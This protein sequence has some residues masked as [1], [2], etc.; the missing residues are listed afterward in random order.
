[1]TSVAA[2]NSAAAQENYAFPEKF[3]LRLA[4]YS[5]E[6]ADTDIAVRDENGIGTSVSF[7]KDLG[8]DTSTTIPR[9]DA[10]YRFNERH[11]VDMTN[12]KIE[13]DGRRV[14][15]IDIDWDDQNYTIGETVVTDISYE[16]FKIGYGYSFYHSRDVE[17]SLTAGLNITSYE[18]EYEL[19]DGSEADSSDVSAPL[20]MFGL[21]MSYAITPRW[22]IHYLAETFFIEIGDELEG[23]FLNYELDLQ[24]KAHKN[25]MLGLGFTRLS[26]DLEADDVEWRGSIND[27]H[28]GY[29]FYLGYQ[30]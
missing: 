11:R 7:A 19:A 22:S 18:F 2:F 17:L 26:I 29:L 15:R 1:M 13:R 10:F 28:R 6:D 23:A 16:L 14:L 20:P 4:S 12:F 24:F 8:G 5:V 25:F 21:R 30:I 27:S 3:T 9:I